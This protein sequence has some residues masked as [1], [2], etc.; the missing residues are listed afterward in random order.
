MLST[1]LS[2]LGTAL[3]VGYGTKAALDFSD[4][5]LVTDIFGDEAEARKIGRFEMEKA[6]R[7]EMEGNLEEIRQLDLQRRLSGLGDSQFVQDPFSALDYESSVRDLILQ[8]QSRLGS[9]AQ[10]LDE[11]PTLEELVMRMG[12]GT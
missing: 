3:G 7:A 10:V 4:R 11:E 5:S 8:N 9:M 1:I 2:A 12:Y 6:R